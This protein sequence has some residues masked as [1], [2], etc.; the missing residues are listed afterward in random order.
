MKKRKTKMKLSEFIEELEELKKEHGDKE[1]VLLMHDDPYQSFFEGEPKLVF[2][3]R[4]DKFEIPT[5]CGDYE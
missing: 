2:D 3:Y 1:V 5:Y 4:S